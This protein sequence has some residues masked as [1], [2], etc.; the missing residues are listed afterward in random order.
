LSSIKPL[1]SGKARD[2]QRDEKNE[3]NEIMRKTIEKGERKRK[4]GPIGG[5]K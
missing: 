3:T 2:E 5:K 4:E 1:N